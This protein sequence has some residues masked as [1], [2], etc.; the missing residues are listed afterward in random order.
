MSQDPRLFFVNLDHFLALNPR[1]NKKDFEHLQEY[2]YDSGSELTEWLNSSQKVLTLPQII[3][4]SSELAQVYKECGERF[5]QSSIIDLI[6]LHRDIHLEEYAYKLRQIIE[7]LDYDPSDTVSAVGTKTVTTLISFGTGDGSVLSSILQLAQ[8][9]NFILV[10]SSWSQF[11]SSFHTIDWKTVYE[12]FSSQHRSIQILRISNKEEA[13]Y[14]AANTCMLGLDHAYVYK[15]RDA[16]E[17]LDE[18]H[19]TLFSSESAN[20]FAYLGYTIDEYNM[21]YNTVGNLKLNS[22]IF[23][24]NEPI[25]SNDCPAIVV[26]SGPSLDFSIEAL[27]QL[28]SSH[29]I[30]AGGSNYKTLVKNN[31]RVDFLT[32]VERD[33]GVYTDFKSIEEYCASQD[34]ILVMS[35]TCVPDL[36][37]IFPKTVVFFRPALTPLA[38]FSDTPL[39]ILPFEGPESINTALSFATQIGFKQIAI[40]GADLGSESRTTTRSADALGATKRVFDLEVDGNYGN[41]VYTNKIMLDVRQMIERSITVGRASGLLYT[42]FSNGVKISG[43][44]PGEILSYTDYFCEKSNAS[45]AEFANQWYA[46]LGGYEDAKVIASW[47]AR[48]PRQETYNLSRQ[49]SNVFSS[50][51]PWFPSV[52][53]QLD[54]LLSLSCPLPSQIPRR[55]MRS[56]LFKLSLAISQQLQ[57]MLKDPQSPVGDFGAQARAM[58]VEVVDRLEQEIYELCDLVEQRYSL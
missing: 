36:Q 7:K 42:N 8:P 6:D 23:R 21:I 13:L 11:V 26:G 5:A 38:L 50:N 55:I 48:N 40:F 52:L 28:Q 46:C 9:Y 27:Q 17:L 53:S 49:L 33:Y 22:K 25:S 10:V 31:I 12:H 2:Q 30:I 47:V 14:T 29:V 32:L 35:T 51:L 1:F 43:A 20:I 4:R 37:K 19:K 54:E 56:T 3:P 57:I 39:E 16:D 34:T 45:V 44:D 58:M 24:R 41:R 18:A 15:A